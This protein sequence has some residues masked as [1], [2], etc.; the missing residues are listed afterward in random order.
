MATP[1]GMGA[2]AQMF[3]AAGEE[4]WRRLLGERTNELRGAVLEAEDASDEAKYVSG[5]NLVMDGTY[6]VTKRP[7]NAAR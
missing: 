7:N 4:E 6:T 1:F 5:H 3:P 2:M